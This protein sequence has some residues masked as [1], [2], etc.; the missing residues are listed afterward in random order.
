[1]ITI[2][3]IVPGER[4]DLTTIGSE[5]PLTLTNRATGEVHNFTGE[6]VAGHVVAWINGRPE[7]GP[8]KVQVTV[9][10]DFDWPEDLA[11]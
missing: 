11:L 6:V 9:K 3:A 5:V 4:A 1:V 7:D 8:A 10:S 2:E